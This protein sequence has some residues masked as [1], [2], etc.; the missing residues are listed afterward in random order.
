MTWHD[1]VSENKPFLQ[2][3]SKTSR[4]AV[5][6]KLLPGRLSIKSKVSELSGANTNFSK[7]L[8]SS[9]KPVDKQVNS[10]GEAVLLFSVT[11]PI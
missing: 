6:Q 2:E 8:L 4:D 1:A 7:F 9:F 5:I 3:A 11:K 10:F